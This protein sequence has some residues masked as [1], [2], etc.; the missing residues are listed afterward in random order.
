MKPGYSPELTALLA[1]CT[2]DLSEERKS[3]LVHLLTQPIFDYDRLYTLADRHRLTGF[4]YRALQQVANVPPEFLTRLRQ[5]CQLTAT[6]NL[7]K[8]HEYR[9][10]ASLLTSQGIDH[11]AYKGVYVAANHYPDSSL[12]PCGDIDILVETTTLADTITLLQAHQYQ[13]N[14][15]HSRY[16]QQGERSLL[17]DL[18]EVSLFKPFF[19]NH[20]DIDLHWEIVCFNR[21]YAAF[22]LRDLLAEPDHAVEWQIVLLVTHHGVTNIW[23]HIFYA[24]DL[25]FLMAGQPIDW[26][27]LLAKLRSYGLEQVFLAGMYWCRQIWGLPLPFAI[28]SEVTTAH[29]SKLATEYEKTWETDHPVALSSLILKQFVL[30]TKAQ[31]RFGKLL[32]ICFTFVT[33]RVF[34]ASTFRIGKRLLF[35]P[36]EL[37]IIT[38]FVRA[39]R[40]VYR[41]LPF[42]R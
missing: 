26:P 11:I 21:H 9:Q 34:R 7:L 13:L 27:W 4:L 18:Y 10:V 3:A 30:F 36:K 42:A 15:K 35:I 25:Y 6:D 16:W 12:R 39:L 17:T 33:S 28:E 1:V 40:S 14:D 41:F 31:T 23:Q 22:R 37:G 24:N 29:I 19:G 8:L 38:V 32:K 20:F 2:T 5:V